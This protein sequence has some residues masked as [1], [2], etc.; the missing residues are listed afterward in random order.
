MFIALSFIKLTF[1]VIKANNQCMFMFAFSP[2]HFVFLVLTLVGSGTEKIHHAA[3]N[4]YFKHA[5][6][7]HIRN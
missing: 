6:S 5:H 7:D 1:L 4:G 3:V 2:V